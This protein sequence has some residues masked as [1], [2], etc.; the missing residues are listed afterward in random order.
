MAINVWRI[1][2]SPEKLHFLQYSVRGVTYAL[3]DVLGH[4]SANCNREIFVKLNLPISV[5]L[6]TEGEKLQKKT[7]TFWLL[8]RI[9]I[10]QICEMLLL[11]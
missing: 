9:G 5:V 3:I 6:V 11:L 10:I 7:S 4:F 2:L 1:P 8:T